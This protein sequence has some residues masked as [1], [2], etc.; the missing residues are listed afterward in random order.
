MRYCASASVLPWVLVGLMAGPLLA[1]ETVVWRD[2]LDGPYTP[3]NP[4]RDIH[5]PHSLGEPP[6]LADTEQNCTGSLPADW[7]AGF[8][9]WHGTNGRHWGLTQDTSVKTE[10][11]ASLHLAYASF[12]ATTADICDIYLGRKFPTVP[13]QRYVLRFDHKM[14]RMGEFWPPGAGDDYVPPREQGWCQYSVVLSGSLADMP[15]IEDYP[16]CHYDETTHTWCEG[17]PGCPCEHPLTRYIFYT[18]GQWHTYAYEFTATGTE[19]AFVWDFRKNRV[20][21]GD[22]AIAPGDGYHLDNIVLST[23]DETGRNHLSNGDFEQ[24]LEGWTAWTVSG[25][26]VT[27]ASS[28]AAMLSG[29]GFNGGLYQ[30][31]YTGGAGNVITVAGSWRG[32]PAEAQNP[33]AEVLVINA[34]RLPADGAD[35]S[36]GSNQAFLA[37]RNDT[38]TGWD[39]PMP[40]SSN[41]GAQSYRIAFTAVGNW[42]T[43]L[44]RA[45]N[46]GNGSS[47]VFFDDIIVRSV[48]APATLDN[49]PAGFTRR[50]L[51]LPFNHMVA[52][53]QSPVSEDLYVVRNDGSSP[54][55]RID[56]DAPVLSAVKIADVASLAGLEFQNGAEGLTFDADGNI[57]ISSHEGDIIKGTYAAGTDSF[58]WSQF[59]D[60][61]EAEVGGWHGVNGLAVDPAGEWLYICSG[62]LKN[63][64][65]SNWWQSTGRDGRILRCSL[66]TGLS[67]AQRLATVDTHVLGI[68]NSFDIV[69]RADGALFGLDNSPDPNIGCDYADEFNRIEPGR[70]YGWPHRY[71]SD[72]SGAD[73]SFQCTVPPTG[74]EMWGEAMANHGP[75][76]R[77]GFGQPGYQDGGVYFGVHPHSSP[78]GLTFYE[79]QRM[80]PGAVKFPEEFHGRAF[81]ARWGQG[82]NPSVG[83]DV[84]SA[85]LSP[86][87]ASYQCNTFLAGAGL[88]NPI[89]VLAA[90][91]GR[92]YVL[93]WGSNPSKLHEISYL[94]PDEPLITL[95]P[96]SLVRDVFLSENL[97]SDSF[98]VTN[99]GAAV[100]EYQI[101]DDVEWL[102]VSPPTGT[103]WGAPVEH[104]ITYD[105]AG[106]PVGTY[107]AE[108]EVTDPA[109]ANSP[110]TLTVTLQVRTVAPDTDHDGDVDQSDYGFLQA[111]YSGPGIAPASQCTAADY[112]HD[113]DVDSG[114][115][116]LLQ[117]CFSGERVR[118]EKDCE[119]PF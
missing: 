119:N 65:D 111:C 16:P 44:L 88:S 4:T 41:L 102:T 74:G 110:Q 112:D 35:E 52:M 55:Y 21:P 89:D 80:R 31:V 24:G 59:L 33:R 2:S 68:R 67:A 81:I 116:T 86:D 76:G 115:F 83:H 47:T 109:A 49:L 3:V 22:P 14:D 105:V 6:W 36:D 60:L 15:G 82:G 54:L 104:A 71:G 51:D 40:A 79:P 90:T 84:L 18:D 23:V 73:N 113:S 99:A 101:N 70:H 62:T 50:T 64:T 78:D 103:S 118:A 77:P 61:P 27:D 8:V 117:R 42:A 91:N 96:K 25:S 29:S 58:A 7:Y 57:Y 43:I 107:A 108:I 106:L 56:P 94:P 38:S 69:F 1:A 97:S 19:T 30:Q 10:G 93:D 63:E 11:S 17:Q 5:N 53:G 114:D 20:Y 9:H 45:A 46:D 39:A 87:D 92:L 48:P 95:D 75:D 66:S 26:P 98:E 100:L 85:R 13:G 34:N 37:Y 32:L 12:G 72:L 28:G